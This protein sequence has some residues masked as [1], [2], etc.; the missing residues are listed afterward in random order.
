MPNHVEKKCPDCWGR[1]IHKST[2]AGNGLLAHYECTSSYCDTGPIYTVNI[3]SAVT[4][5]DPA[6]QLRALK[7]LAA[8]LE[9]D[10]KTMQEMLEVLSK[11]GG[12][13]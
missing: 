3:A 8:S 10:A 1:L 13:G 9:D 12:S 5:N 7:D 2:P 4:Q 11:L 6:P